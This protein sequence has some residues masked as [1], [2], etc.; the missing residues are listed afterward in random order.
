[1]AKRRFQNPKPKR[2][3]GWWYI[4]PRQEK[5]G[6]GRE[7][8]RVKLAR[9]SKGLR[10]VQKI[11]RDYLRTVN[12]GLEAG[13]ACSLNEFVET[14]YIPAV[15]PHLAKPVRDC[16]EGLLEKRIKPALGE[17]A[18]R[19]MTP[20]L[21]RRHFCRM[22]EEKIGC[23]TIAKA[24]DALSSVLRAAVEAQLLAKNPL[25]GLKLPP[26][27]R[28]RRRKPVISPE[29]FG[30]MVD[31]IPEP[32]ATMVYVAVWTGL[33][34]SE[35]AA[36]KWRCVHADSITVEERYCRGDWAAPK[37]EASAATIGVQRHVV[38]RIERLK[39][40]T[41]SIRAGK[42]PGATKCSVRKYKAV[43]KSGPE[44]LVFQ[45]VRDGKPMNA[46]NI[47]RRY[48][49]P[50]ARFARVPWVDWRCLRRSHATWLVEAGA[51]PKA[52][53]GQMRHARISATMDIYAQIVAESQRRALNA[54]DRFARA[55]RPAVTLLS[56]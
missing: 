19:E 40:I 33:R 1:M 30:R 8:V 50:A 3:G 41:L 20:L 21:L 48:L 7:L 32:Y 22:A 26:D 6:G 18:L 23:P 37:T 45:S 47:L 13:A 43:K 51:E 49:K 31:A 11:A 16:Y 9:S 44:D 12:D 39:G 10:E 2:E 29:Q 54:L 27:R 53:Q 56:Q 42:L 34:V 35:L 4:R 5:S 25:L 14:T 15:L 46:G 55:A 36:L 38:E 28:A 52:V 24:R 17:Y